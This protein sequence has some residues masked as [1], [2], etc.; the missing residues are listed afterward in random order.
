MAAGKVTMRYLLVLWSFVC[1]V[2]ECLSD[3]FTKWEEEYQV[4]SCIS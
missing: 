2:C 4:Q 1:S 3:L